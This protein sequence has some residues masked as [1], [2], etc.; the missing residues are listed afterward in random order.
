MRLENGLWRRLEGK[1]NEHGLEPKGNKSHR[2]VL[3]REG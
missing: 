1:A 3:S 2:K